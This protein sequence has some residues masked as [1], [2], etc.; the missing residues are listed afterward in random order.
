[1]RTNQPQTIYLSEYQAPAYLVDHVNLRFE[2][3]EDGAR[4]HS[5]LSMRRNPAATQSGSTLELDGDSLTLESLALNGQS[6]ASD[7]YRNE[8]DKLVVPTVPEAFELTVV[9]WI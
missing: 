5:T 1:M 4:V 3:F 9:T 7:E 6:L 2:L 8:G